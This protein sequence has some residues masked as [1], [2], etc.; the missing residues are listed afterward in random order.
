M[1]RF[2]YSVKLNDEGRPYVDIPEEYQ[3][4]PEDKFMALEL[5]RYLLMNV[6]D[7]RNHEL[8]QDSNKAMDATL[9]TLEKIS[10]EVA[11]ILKKEMEVRGENELTFKRNYHIQ[12]KSI[13]ER[14]KLRYEGIIYDDKIYSRNPGLK[15]LVLETMAIYELVKG[16]DNENWVEVNN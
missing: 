15:V 5:C 3:D 4:N 6:H 12:V 16:I 11:N 14:D 8:D 1:L 10:D 9:A 7:R 2:E 13:V